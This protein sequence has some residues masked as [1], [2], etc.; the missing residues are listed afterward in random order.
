MP[1]AGSALTN[2]PSAEHYHEPVAHACP[3]PFPTVG[4]PSLVREG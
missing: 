4:N 2:V 3:I 1:A